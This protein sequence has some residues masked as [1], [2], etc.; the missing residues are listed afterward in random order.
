MKVL[1]GIDGSD[2]SI[3]AV[4]LTS[5][6]ISAEQDEIV[7]YYSPPQINLCS[8]PKPD[9]E[10]IARMQKTLT[11]AV[12]DKA[13]VQLSTRLNVKTTTVVGTRPP[14]QGLLVQADEC[15]A[16]MIVVGARGSGPFKRLPLGSVGRAVAHA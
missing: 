9:D 1:I 8:G 10:T 12:F 13:R 11:D 16:D 2:N 5:R 15:R 3:E 14:K 4:R 6:L 7:L